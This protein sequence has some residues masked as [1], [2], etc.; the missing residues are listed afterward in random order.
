[1][2]ETA[3]KVLV[4]E[5]EREAMEGDL[6]SEAAQ[7]GTAGS[8]TDS[9]AQAVGLDSVVAADWAGWAAAA[10]TEAGAGMEA[11]AAAAALAAAGSAAAEAAANPRAVRAVKG[12]AEAALAAD[13]GTGWVVVAL[14]AAGL[15]AAGWAAVGWAAAA[16]RAAMATEAGAVDWAAETCRAPRQLAVPGA[17]AEREAVAVAP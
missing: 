12:V 14:A 8:E 11:E 6:G 17:P 16:G 4:L 5:V 9:E 1:M 13:W 2:V 3:A 15:V 10:A 7:A